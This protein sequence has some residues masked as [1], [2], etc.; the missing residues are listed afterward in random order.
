[1][2]VVVVPKNNQGMTLLEVMVAM[3]LLTMVTAMVYSIMDRAIVFSEKGEKKLLALE[4]RQ[5]LLSLLERQVRSGWYDDK[6]K[7]VLI[8]GDEEV[9]RLVTRSPLLYAGHGTVLALYSYDPA[10][11]TLYYTE[12]KDFYNP[13]YDEVVPE[14]DEMEVLL[15]KS[16]DFELLFDEDVGKVTLAW[17]GKEYEFWP[18]CTERPEEDNDE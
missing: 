2:K 12:R 5:A 8:S 13:D 15:E 6:Q 9:L 16:G 17:Q 1:M 11:Q 14:W 10:E 18:W 4:Q 3:L 7:K